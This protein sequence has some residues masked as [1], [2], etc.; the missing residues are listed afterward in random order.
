MRVFSR[1]CLRLTLAWSFLSV[2][3]TGRALPQSDP[4]QSSLP[5]PPGAIARLDGGSNPFLCMA[6]SPDGKCLASGGYERTIS[7]WDIASGKK[8]QSWEGP[9]P[10]VTAIAFAPD[11]TSIATGG[12]QDKIVHLWEVASQRELRQFIGL[13]RGASSLSFS[14]DGRFL[15]AGGSGA[16][17]VFVWETAS[18]KLVHQL[19]GAP[20]TASDPAMNAVLR[21]APEF[22]HAAYSGDGKVLASGHTR[23]LLRIWD[24]TTFHE[25]NHFRGPLDDAFV[26]VGISPD[27][28][29]LAGWGSTIR[30][31]DLASR[32][33]IRFF[34]EQPG[35]RVGCIAFSRDGRVLASGSYTR[36]SGD[37]VVHIWEIASGQERCKLEG[38]RYA[39]SSVVFPP[40]GATLVSGS[41]DG[42]ALVWNVRKLPQTKPGQPPAKTMEMNECWRTL[43]AGDAGR[44]FRAMRAMI[45]SPAEATAL[46]EEQMAATLSVSGRRLNQLLESLDSNSFH[47]RENATDELALQVEVAEA[48]IRKAASAHLSAEARTRLEMVL[49]LH[50]RAGYN[51][52]QIQRIRALEVLEN[53]PSDESKKLLERIAGG[54]PGFR[55]TRA[56]R[57]SLDRLANSSSLLSKPKAGG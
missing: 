50:D 30:V 25:L 39:V 7:L 53:I 31:W 23:G 28:A 52:A 40:G 46:L 33:Q 5:L 29:F 34:G 22:S 12:V 20:D 3:A 15:T 21:Q 24:A 47:E 8:T 17:E 1:I 45:G 27:N 35:L 37:N 36:D 56:A 18:G 41:L 43:A 6:V 26:H 44:A 10:N 13:P 55:I 38:H 4:G 32:K 14:P 16:D 49:A 11:G 51:A 48:A 9:E 54:D 42:T 2:I 19:Q 57:A